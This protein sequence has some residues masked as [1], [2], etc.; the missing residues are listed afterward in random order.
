M[1]Q[2]L[3]QNKATLFSQAHE[4]PPLKSPWSFP[5]HGATSSLPSRKCMANKR[6]SNLWRI[7]RVD[8]SWVIVAQKGGLET[9][10]NTTAN[11]VLKQ[12]SS[13]LFWWEKHQHA[14][15]DVCWASKRAGVLNNSC[16]FSSSK[17]QDKEAEEEKEEQKSTTA[18]AATTTTTTTATTT[19]TTTTTPPATTT[20]TTRVQRPSMAAHVFHF[21]L[22]MIHCHL[23]WWPL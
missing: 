23:K 18:A 9:S 12:Q 21:V 19:T 6:K 20:T 10:K 14:A 11:S 15:N 22:E 8:E 4:A 16:S 7:K 5:S 17:E 3:K 13:L 1:L 2:L